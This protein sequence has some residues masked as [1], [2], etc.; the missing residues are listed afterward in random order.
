MSATQ[1]IEKPSSIQTVAILT[2][3]SG[4]VNV[5]WGLGITAAVVFGTLFF[6][7]IC[8]PLTLLPAILGIFEIIYASQ[9]LANPPTTR[10]PS[11]ALAIFQIVGILSANVVSF[12]TG[13]LALVVYSNPETK[14]YFA[15]LNPQ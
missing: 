9:L 12:I 7:I 2:L 13:I 3:I 1:I 6:G 5:L 14:E 4:I 8:A 15:S 10:Q 11:Q